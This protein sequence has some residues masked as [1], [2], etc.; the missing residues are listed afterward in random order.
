[1]LTD[2]HLR[3]LGIMS[4]REFPDELFFPKIEIYCEYLLRGVSGVEAG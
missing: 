1:M 2:G 4:F 3:Q